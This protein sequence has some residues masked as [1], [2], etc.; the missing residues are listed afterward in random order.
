[1]KSKAIKNHVL[2]EKMR[3]DISAPRARPDSNST[4]KKGHDSLDQ[5]IERSPDRNIED[6][7]PVLKNNSN[8]SQSRN[9]YSMDDLLENGSV[10]KNS[11]NSSRND[12]R[13][14]W[15]QPREVRFDDR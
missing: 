9:R 6:K 10:N 5:F 8:Y 11:D 4:N 2:A 15:A 1:M 7:A 3:R 13:I 14:S 12:N